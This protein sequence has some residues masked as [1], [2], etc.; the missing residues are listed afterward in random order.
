MQSFLPGSIGPVAFAGTVA[1]AVSSEDR[2]ALSW[3]SEYLGSWFAHTR[4]AADWRMRLSVASDPWALFEED[5][6]GALVE[7]ACYGLDAGVVSL[8]AVQRRGALRIADRERSCFFDLGPGRVDLVGAA[9]SPRWRFSAVL[10]LLGIIAARMRRTSLDLHA[11]ALDRG[12][13]G[14]WSWG[15]RAR[16]RRRWRPTCSVRADV[17]R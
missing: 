12:G 4:R 6:P 7:R 14:L 5:T 2:G 10:I 17:P 13:R 8:P 3:L 15:R 11:A 9:D 1:V 16:E